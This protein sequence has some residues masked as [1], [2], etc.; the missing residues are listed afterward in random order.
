MN[1]TTVFSLVLI[2]VIVLTDAKQN[3]PSINTRSTTANST[4]LRSSASDKV[5]AKAARSE[6]PH[7]G[8]EHHYPHHFGHVGGFGH[9]KEFE[10]LLLPLLIVLGLG[11]LFM[12][13][14]GMLMTTLVGNVPVTTLVSG[15]KR[16]DLG[17]TKEMEQTIMDLWG[18]VEK[19]VAAF[20]KD[21]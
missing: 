2:C 15:R 20:Q 8:Y 12:P 1:S 7:H 5:T 10:H 17:V 18:K 16:R 11:V 4:N 3:N 14:L 19:A 21:L 9:Y 6:F 13:I